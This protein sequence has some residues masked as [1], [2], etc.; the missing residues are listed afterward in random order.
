[1]AKNNAIRTARITD[2]KLFDLI[3]TLWERVQIT[4]VRVE[5]GANI[6][7]SV[8]PKD[9]TDETMAALYSDRYA[10]HSATITTQ[11]G[12]RITFYR[13]ICDN[14]DAP[15]QRQPSPHF[16]ELFFIPNDKSDHSQVAA[17]L[18][19]CVDVV[20]EVL[21]SVYPFQ[22]AATASPLPARTVRFFT[23][24]ALLGIFR[25]VPGASHTK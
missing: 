1:M 11:Q 24:R 10:I 5:L 6:N 7:L 4:D 17:H 13:G 16:D 8:P 25:R 15:H 14:Q 12:L 9:S 2:K 18:A 21:G 20:E 19:E 23:F 22:G 3:Y